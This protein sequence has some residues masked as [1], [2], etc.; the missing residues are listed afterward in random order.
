MSLKDWLNNGWLKKHKTSSEEIQNL[1]M[2]IT[3]DLSDSKNPDLSYDWRFAIAY[4]AALQICTTAL[5]CC[6][7]KPARGQSEHYRVIQSL[8]LTLGNEYSEI[9]IYL[10]ACRAKRN[11]SDYD[12]AGTISN[13]EVNEIISVTTE[14]FEE[15]KDQF[16]T[17]LNQEKF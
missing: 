17:V 15:L 14:L 11:I 3:R 7:Y 8:P 5:Y 6:G 2:I 4:N 16:E 13:T 10:N 1:L 9:S 12:M